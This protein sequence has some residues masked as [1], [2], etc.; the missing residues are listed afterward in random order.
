MNA[1]KTA[2]GLIICFLTSLSCG[3]GTGGGGILTMFL[4]LFSGV[5]QLQAQGMNL[6]AFSFAAAPSAAVSNIRCRPDI[7]IITFFAFCGAV[8]CVIGAIFASYCPENAMRKAYGA[9]LIMVSFYSIRT[10]AK[11]KAG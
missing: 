2:A 1:A 7:R 8:G 5:P 6:L 3:M 9:F 10:S 11:G 4:T